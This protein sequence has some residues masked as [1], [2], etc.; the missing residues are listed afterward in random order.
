MRGRGRFGQRGAAIKS[1]EA[2]AAAP[3]PVAT[4][5][6][7]D[8]RSCA[9]CWPDSFVERGYYAGHAGASQTVHQIQVVGA[10]ADGGDIPSSL[11]QAPMPWPQLLGS[12]GAVAFEPS[13]RDIHSDREAA[14]MFLEV[15]YGTTL[16]ARPDRVR[17]V[18]VV[19]RVPENPGHFRDTHRA[20]VARNFFVMRG[21]R[22]WLFSLLEFDHLTRRAR[23]LLVEISPDGSFGCQ[24]D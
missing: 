6:E 7:V 24:G 12:L 18:E 20:K 17:V 2:R 8:D 21:Y 5:S 3:L 16:V 23:R 22:T 13:V 19:D 14:L 15:L 4:S 11:P 10:V 9:V 1:L